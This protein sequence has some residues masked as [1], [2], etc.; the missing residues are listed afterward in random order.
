MYP[1]RQTSALNKQT[2]RTIRALVGGDPDGANLLET[3]LSKAENRVVVKR[4]HKA[5]LLSALKPSHVITTKNSR[6]DVYL[7]FNAR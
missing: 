1:H 7:T 6:F 3:A 4:P 5:P 2:L